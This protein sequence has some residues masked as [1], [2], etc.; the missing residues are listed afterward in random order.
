VPS[1][2][3]KELDFTRSVFDIKLW[4]EPVSNVKALRFL[5]LPQC[6]LI[7]PNFDELLTIVNR[8]RSLNGVEKQ[9]SCDRK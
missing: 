3:L 5:D 4:F 8:M 2:S 7:T 9:Y 6:D 1:S